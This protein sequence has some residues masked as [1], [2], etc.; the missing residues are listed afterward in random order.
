MY[1]RCVYI[2]AEHFNFENTATHARTR[3]M[4]SS[5]HFSV[6]LPV[7]NPLQGIPI[8]SEKAAV[9]SLVN[10]LTLARVMPM[11]KKR[12]HTHTHTHTHSLT[13]HTRNVFHNSILEGQIRFTPFP[14]LLSPPLLVPP[15]A[16]FAPFY[17]P[18]SSCS[19]SRPPRRLKNETKPEPA[20]ASR[21]L[22]GYRMFTLPRTEAR[23]DGVACF[24][25]DGIHV[26]DKQVCC[27]SR[28]DVSRLF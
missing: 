26:L 20:P 16:S 9:F 3:G 17:V 5:N 18:T 1:Q 15:A 6:E 25:K 19:W 2:R 23:G 14:S 11:K 12:T 4:L 8:L 10:R 13:R 7:R 27:V 28:V 21:S 22:Q 24:V